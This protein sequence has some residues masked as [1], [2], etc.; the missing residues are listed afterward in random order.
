MSIENYSLGNN[1]LHVLHSYA[2]L[3]AGIRAC[4]Y[5]Y[6]WSTSCYMTIH[7]QLLEKVYFTVFQSFAVVLVT[8]RACTIALP[9]LYI[10]ILVHPSTFTV[11]LSVDV[12][13]S[14]LL[15]ILFFLQFIDTD[16]EIMTQPDANTP[17]P[18]HWQQIWPY[19]W[20]RTLYHRIIPLYL[21][22]KSVGIYWLQDTRNGMV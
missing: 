11:E 14:S 22:F 8:T 3:L 2:T 15:I 5:A 19:W 9:L 1:I 12:R 7:S 17:S 16:F 18:S 20:A 13:Y 10:N 6:E 21:H 4:M